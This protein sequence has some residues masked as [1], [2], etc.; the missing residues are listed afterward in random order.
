MNPVVIVYGKANSVL[1]ILLTFHFNFYGN[2]EGSLMAKVE[3][4]ECSFWER[5]DKYVSHR[6]ENNVI[7]CG[8]EQ[9]EMGQKVCTCCE[10]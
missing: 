3:I 4:L 7:L 1:K 10:A 5:N 6:I 9:E 2:L 8:Q